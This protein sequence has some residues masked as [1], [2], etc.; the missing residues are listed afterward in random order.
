MSTINPFTINYGMSNGFDLLWTNL[1][2][3]S[4]SSFSEQDICVPNFLSYN[5]LL[6]MV[7]NNVCDTGVTSC[8]ISTKSLM[9]FLETAMTSTVSDPGYAEPEPLPELYS[10][11]I[12][13]Y[14]DLI[15]PITMKDTWS[16]HIG[17]CTTDEVLEYWLV[18]GEYVL[19]D[20][21]PAEGTYT[22]INAST[23]SVIPLY[24]YGIR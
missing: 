17:L 3:A 22:P 24:I 2:I 19:L 8:I 15:R 1:A 6:I 18:D 14:T 21:T 16:I 11:S 9:N 10:V 5:F 20:Y 12:N 7:Q 23:D 13:S 4:P